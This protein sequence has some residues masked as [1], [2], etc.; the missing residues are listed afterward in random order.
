MTQNF[1]LKTW[2]KNMI[3]EFRANHGKV[4]QFD[5]VLLLTT[6]GRKSGNPYTTPLV[7][8]KDGD[9]LLVFA[10]KAGADTNPDWYH[11]LVANPRVTLEVGDEKFDA[12][13]TVTQAEERD[14]LYAAQEKRQPQFTEYQ[15]KTQR[16]I[17]VVALERV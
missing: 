1:D 12:T 14:R 16:K 15:S 8:M 10:S 3:E 13:A 4:T 17:P 6:T 5:Q 7:Y 9:R 2:N 11:N